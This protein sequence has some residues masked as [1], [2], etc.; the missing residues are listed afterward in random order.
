MTKDSWDIIFGFVQGIGALATAGSLIYIVRQVK[1]QK[2]EIGINLDYQKREKAL[3]MCEFYETLI[4]DMSFISYIYEKNWKLQKLENKFE[5]QE[6][7][8]EEFLKIHDEESLGKFMIIPVELVLDEYFE[9]KFISKHFDKEFDLKI[10]NEFKPRNYTF[11]DEKDIQERIKGLKDKKDIE[12]KIE[13]VNVLN[14][15]LFDLKETIR[16]E[17]FQNV[18]GLLNKLEF[19]SMNFISGI[20]DESVVYQSLHQSFFSIVGFFYPRICFF[21]SSSGKDKYFTNLIE[22]HN[23][24]KERERKQEEKER[25]FKKELNNTTISSKSKII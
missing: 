4:K 17:F 20:A 10:Y 8:K 6:F 24:W 3:E 22:L 15:E 7:N 2:K 21:N 23:I 16:N 12:E 14:K 5:M 13:E 9:K 11:L 19:F 18:S 1:L 25:Q